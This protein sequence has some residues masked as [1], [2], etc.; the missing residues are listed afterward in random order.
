VHRRLVNWP[1]YGLNAARTHAAPF[2]LVPPFRVIWKQTGD[3]SLIE[4]PPIVVDGRLYVGTNHGLVLALDAAT[5][6]VVWRRQLGRCI[7]SSPVITAGALIVGVMAAPP[8]CDADIA[9]YVIALDARD[10]RTRWLRHSRGPVETSPLVENGTVAFGSWDGRVVALD[11]ATGSTRWTFA[12]AGPIKAGVAGKNST[13]YVASYDGSMSAL[14]ARS[15]RVRWTTFAGAPFY[16]TP[17]VA[18]TRV[19]AATTDGVVHALASG[20]GAVLWTRRIGRFVYSA[21]AVARG[22]VFIGS[23]DHRLYALD[24]RTGRALWAHSAPGPV[25]GAPTVLGRLVYYS[26]CG[27][28]SRYEANPR[29]RRTFAVEAANGSEVWSFPD[30]EYSPVVTDG[31]RLYLTGYTAVYALVPKS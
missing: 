11:A 6:R 18:G 28:C 27:S 19:I 4:F 23:Y 2:E 12:T 17:T 25:S 7:A 5:G 16:A 8:R 9:S 21:A 30:G 31:V 24:V 14:D 15:G 29:A 22:R 20:S 26:S 10:G 13:L 1:T 3:R